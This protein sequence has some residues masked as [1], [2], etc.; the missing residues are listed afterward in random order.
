[1]LVG[2]QDSK[3]AAANMEKGMTQAMRKGSYYTPG[4]ELAKQLWRDLAYYDRKPSEWKQSSR[5][6][7]AAIVRASLNS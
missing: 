7:R 4:M 6:A 5:M 1:M 2:E 3:T